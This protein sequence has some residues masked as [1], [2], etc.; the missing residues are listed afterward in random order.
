MK[1]LLIWS[2]AFNSQWVS[3]TAIFKN[4]EDC[5]EMKSIIATSDFPAKKGYI[6]CQLIESEKSVTGFEKAY[7]R[8]QF[9]KV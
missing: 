1:Y 3:G 8:K 5:L 2:I 6:E 4:L 9:Q 7:V